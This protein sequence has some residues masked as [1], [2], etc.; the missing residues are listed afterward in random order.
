MFEWECLDLLSLEKNVDSWKHCQTEQFYRNDKD[1]KNHS[2]RY[3]ALL[4]NYYSILHK[5]VTINQN[6]SATEILEVLRSGFAARNQICS[7]LK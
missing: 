6:E 7:M 4:P 2:S 3:G 1:P 5:T